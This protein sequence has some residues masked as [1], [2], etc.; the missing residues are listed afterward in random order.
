MALFQSL[1][2]DVKSAMKAHDQEKLLGLRTLMS[3]VKKVAIDA[4]RREPSDEDFLTAAAK[5]IKQRE[6]SA[7]QFR[8]GGRP[9]L[10][11]QEEAQI[12]WIRVYMPAQMSKEELEAVIR[13]TVAA[14][15]AT[16]KK[17]MGKVMGALMPKV[18]GKAD[19]KLVNQIV[20]SLLA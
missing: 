3:D 17:D 10:A 12:A 18:K 5:S 1:M 16:S 20:Q 15:G 8:E 2:E 19:G 4:G 14:V 9:E 13:E 11:E 7:A 6:D